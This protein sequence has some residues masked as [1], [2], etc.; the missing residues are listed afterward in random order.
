MH[1]NGL[2]HLLKAA[3]SCINTSGT[4]LTDNTQVT[5]PPSAPPSVPVQVTLS[6]RGHVVVQLGI[7]PP[8]GQ[9]HVLVQFS[10]Q[11]APGHGHV[12]VQLGVQLLPGRHAGFLQ[13]TPFG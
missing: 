7:Q 10:V 6:R 2:L 8:L 13:A 1:T 4:H 5:T 3:A 12:V 11:P 9:R